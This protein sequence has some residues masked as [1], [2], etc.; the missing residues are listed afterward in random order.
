MGKDPR[1]Y[2]ADDKTPYLE[3]I[4]YEFEMLVG[5]FN[6]CFSVEPAKPQTLDQWTSYNLRVEG[7]AFHARQLIEFLGEDNDMNSVHFGVPEDVRDGWGATSKKLKIKTNNHVAHLTWARKSDDAANAGARAWRPT[8][9]DPLLRAGEAFLRHL[10]GPKTAT[11]VAVGSYRPRLEALLA[12]YT[13]CN[14]RDRRLSEPPA[15]PRPFQQGVATGA[16]QSH[17][18]ADIQ[19]VRASISSTTTM[20]NVEVKTVAIKPAGSSGS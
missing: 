11:E 10:V 14:S 7:L 1:A 8:D 5:C 18:V 13:D 3:H 4:V 2:T 16:A 17:V 9:L 6:A 19:F 20:S 15:T 12:A